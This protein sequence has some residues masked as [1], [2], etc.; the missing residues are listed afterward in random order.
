ME[1]VDGSSVS[2]WE[3]RAIWLIKQVCDACAV[4]RYMCKASLNITVI[5]SM[6]FKCYVCMVSTWDV[7]NVELCLLF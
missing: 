2:E 3:Q 5:M 1:C 4:Q 7:I 6:H